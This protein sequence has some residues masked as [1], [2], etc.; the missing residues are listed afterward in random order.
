ML[1]GELEELK[2]ELRSQ[3]KTLENL[4]R[5]RQRQAAAAFCNASAAREPDLGK[6]VLALLSDSLD[7]IRMNRNAWLRLDPAA[8]Q[9]HPEITELLRENQNLILKILVLDR[10]SEPPRR[11]SGQVPREPPQA[12]RAETHILSRLYRR[13]STS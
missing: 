2:R 6:N 13:V 5:A 7:R 9:G 8:K 10:E 1:T 11:A 3:R 4:L 12:A